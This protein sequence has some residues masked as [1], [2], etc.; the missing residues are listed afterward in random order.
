MTWLRF[1]YLLLTVGI[2]M[3]AV[4]VIPLLLIAHYLLG[5]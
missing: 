3:V 1:G 4:S 2:V 5:Q